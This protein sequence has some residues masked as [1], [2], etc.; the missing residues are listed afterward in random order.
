MIC[1]KVLSC[2]FR[3]ALIASVGKKYETSH[4][5][6]ELRSFSVSM[7]INLFFL[8]IHFLANLPALQLVVGVLIN[9]TSTSAWHWIYDF[10]KLLL[11]M[12]HEL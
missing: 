11:K 9:L 8:Y 4:L 6:L 7:F 1:T 3:F 10:L 12:G 5:P 2:S